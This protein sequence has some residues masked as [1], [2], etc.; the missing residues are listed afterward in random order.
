MKVVLDTNV[1]HDKEFLKWLK[2]SP[3]EPILSA[4]AYTEYLYHHAKKRGSY[5][6]GKAYVDAFLNALGI[7][8]YPFDGEC[9]KIVV[10]NALGRWDFSKNAR[11]YMIGALAV[12]LNAPLITNNKKDFEWYSKVYTPNEFMKL[13]RNK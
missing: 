12:K 10:K 1:F 8:V 11:D 2:K 4:V 6:E 5:E 13:M 3:H 7:R 9:A